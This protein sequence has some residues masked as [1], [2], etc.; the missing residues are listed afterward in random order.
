M[1]QTGAMLRRHRILFIIIAIIVLVPLALVVFIATFDWNRARPWL[2]SRA[3]EAIGRSVVL[4]GDLL[5]SWHWR[6][7]V[8]GTDAWSPGFRFNATRVRIGNPDW[9]KAANFAELRG[10]GI[11]LRLLPLLWREI[12]IPSV[13]L[14]QP[15]LDLERRKDGSTNW[16][17]LATANTPSAWKF[18]LGEIE[19]DA[20]KVTLTD[21]QRALDLHAEITALDAPIAFG[22][23]VEGDDPSTRREVIQRVGRDAAQRLRKAAQERV[24]R[25]PAR[26]GMTPLP[27]RFAWKANG[28][29]RG[30][31]VTGNG[32]LGGVF[33][34]NDARHPFPLR[35]DIDVGSTEISLTGTITDPT[36]P[37]AIDMRLWIS[38]PNL[39]ELYPIAG[40]ALPN[41]P[42]YAT[43]GRLA[44]S[45]HPHRSVLRY[46][47]FTARVG[48]SDL[49]GSLTYKSAD[50]RA[51]LSGDVESTLLQFKDLG[52]L[53]G[54]GA[55]GGRDVS[56]PPDRVLPGEPFNV[57]RWHAMD[58]DVHFTG[59]RVVRD[60]ELPI[61]DVDAR[62]VMRDAVLTLDPLRFAMAGGTVVATLR[63]DANAQLPR[64]TLALDAHKLQLR[65]LFEK[66][67][68]LSSSLGDVEGSIKLA[69]NGNSIATLLGS[70]DGSVKALMI[71]GK[72]S[73]KLMEEAGLNVANILAVKL[74]GDR[75][76]GI[77]CTAADFSAK[78]GV[79]RANLFVFDT[80]NALIDIEGDIRLDDERVELI[81]HPHTKS[82]RVFS[83]R[84]PLHVDGDFH[85]VAI[86]IDKKTLLARVGGAIGLGLVAAPLAALAAL[87]APRGEAQKSCAPLVA[88]VSHPAR[89]KA[90]AAKAAAPARGHGARR[91]H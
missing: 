77:N 39:A 6:R 70:S 84:S 13:R 29:L 46:E 89:G 33:A 81:L 28:T 57:E 90:K 44:G 87:V 24:A 65:R 35:A 11:D 8:G 80:D 5:A 9:A 42:P 18:G 25:H 82:L 51:M 22:E 61:S 60:E 17:V 67:Q 62:I 64:G 7:R 1:Q 41:T 71:D 3:S 21:A 78:D 30:R 52:A 75:Q 85:K 31:K 27:Y 36:S 34:L 63:I 48:G 23:R 50:P 12:S 47:D 43:V 53:V 59:K 74:A 83:L 55:Y 49:D 19:L 72:V 15:S 54:A 16:P 73:E 26:A 66:V 56:A 91:K 14:L 20:G 32:R 40:L 38:G 37:D 79:L 45:F 10:I 2:Q 86:S 68:G 88:W 58:A 69:G 4:E 76:I